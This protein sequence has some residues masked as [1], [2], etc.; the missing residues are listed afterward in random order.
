MGRGEGCDGPPRAQAAATPRRLV[1]RVGAGAYDVTKWAPRHPGGRTLLE[2]HCDGE[3]EPDAAD[4]FEAFHPPGGRARAMLAA[5]PRVAPLEAGVPSSVCAVAAAHADAEQDSPSP[6]HVMSGGLVAEEPHETTRS[7]RAA[8]ITSAFRALRKELELEGYF[9]P[10][11]VAIAARAGRCAA[12]AAAATVLLLGAPRDDIRSGYRRALALI[13]GALMLGMLYAQGLLF[14]HDI[15]HLSVLT[16]ARERQRA[17]ALGW[18]FGTVVGGIGGCWWREDHNEHH[19]FPNALGV[20]KSAGAAPFL[21]I[22]ARQAPLARRGSLTRL[23]LRTQVVLYLPLCLLVARFNL[24]VV[25]LAASPAPLASAA[26]L[27]DA[28]GICAHFAW[29][30]ALLRH[31]ACV[32]ALEVFAVYY[33]AN[34]AC[35][36]LHL[37][38]NLNHYDLAMDTLQE[39]IAMPW[40]ERQL[41][42]SMN[43]STYSGKV[44]GSV[45]TTQLRHHAAACVVMRAREGRW[46]CG[47]RFLGLLC[48]RDC[49]SP[50]GVPDPLAHSLTIPTH[51]R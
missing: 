15:L 17:R 28:L 24:H 27:A 43:V 13:L 34:V 18:L 35:S 9:E 46:C 1:L 49:A 51:A 6:Q 37:Q 4:A 19:A 47:M 22:D 29:L 2:R 33:G 14:A 44:R 45:H 39:S 40:C 48:Q 41:R 31:S 3:G 25:S 12:F 5:M 7:I 11:A 30:A 36:I 32:S 50:N 26:F 10:S 8:R 16:R 42:R 23:A 21:C 38:L 20:D